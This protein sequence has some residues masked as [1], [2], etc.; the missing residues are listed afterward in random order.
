MKSASTPFTF[1]PTATPIRQTAATRLQHLL[2]QMVIYFC[3]SNAPRIQHRGDRPS[4]S[5]Y[6]VFDPITGQSHSF[7]SAAEVRAWLDTRYSR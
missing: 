2:R 6:R 1:V 4:Q 5:D 3:G 7:D